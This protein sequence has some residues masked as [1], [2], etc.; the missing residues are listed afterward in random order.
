MRVTPAMAQR[1]LLMNKRNRPLSPKQVGLYAKDMTEERWK[2]NGESIKFAGQDRLIDGQHRLA[3]CVAANVPFDTLVSTGLDAEAFDTIDC[4]RRRGAADTFAVREEKNYAALAAALVIVKLYD[5]GNVSY[6]SRLTAEGATNQ[7]YEKWLE[8]YPK[9]RE[10]VAVAINHKTAVLQP[11]IAA[12]CHFIFSRH[13][14]SDADA[15]MTSLL[16]G[17]GI[18]RGSA[19]QKLQAVLI[20]NASS[21]KKMYRGELLGLTIKTWNAFRG[22]KNIQ[23]MRSVDGEKFPVAQ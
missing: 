22:K 9:I 23:R 2:M 17:T 10:S 19:L 8:K 13:S 21:S 15:F 20:Q 16:T 18:T 12:A 1:W 6:G 7:D 5:D 14:R 11:S 3:A 4:G